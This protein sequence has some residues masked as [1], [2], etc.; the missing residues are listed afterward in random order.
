MRPAPPPERGGTLR[1]GRTGG[2]PEAGAR[3]QGGEALPA[4]EHGSGRRRAAG[5]WLAG[6]ALPLLAFA[7]LALGVMAQRPFAFDAPVLLWMRGHA[8]PG[9]DRFFLLVSAVGHKY[10]VIP[11]DVAAVLALAALRRWR[12]AGFAASAFVGSALL[13]IG[14][15]AW[16]QRDR[17]ALWE[18]I[19]HEPNFS[20]PSGHAMGSS[21]LALTAIALAWP[22]RWRWP[23]VAAG[24]VFVL[25]VGLSRVYLGVHYPS[26]IVAGWLLAAAWVVAMHQMW[27]ARAA[28]PW[29]A[30]APRR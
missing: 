8:G 17:P 22:T 20:F 19:V 30:S 5:W 13:N 24:G 29:A 9:A 16:F 14:G 12:E 26:D 25:L 15:K 4:R 7:L 27:F 1:T 6:A 2:A 23:A 11:V 3:G 28:R 10:G 21:T 18:A